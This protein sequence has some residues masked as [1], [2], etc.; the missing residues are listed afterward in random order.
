M[1]KIFPV[2]ILSLL[3]PLAFGGITNAQSGNY[4]SEEEYQNQEED[5]RDYQMN[6]GDAEYYET[7]SKVAAAEEQEERESAEADKA[8]KK[9]FMYVAL[10]VAGITLIYVLAYLW[11]KYTGSSNFKK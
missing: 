3:I 9:L 4:M 1:K 2:L 8:N 10:G 5:Y 6:K 7:E 11:E